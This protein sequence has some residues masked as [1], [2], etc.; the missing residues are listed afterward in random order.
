M[1]KT[2]NIRHMLRNQKHWNPF[3]DQY[4]SEKIKKDLES[5][6]AAWK[7]NDEKIP[8]PDDQSALTIVK[9][10]Q[11]FHYYFKQVYENM[12]NAIDQTK[13]HPEHV[14]K[15]LVAIG[16]SD[17]ILL[18]KHMKENIIHGSDNIR[19][20]EI[21]EFKIEA[22]NGGPLVNA[23]GA[24][25]MQVD[26]LTNLLNYLRYF[27]DTKGLHDNYVEEEIIKISSYLYTSS[28]IMFSVKD[29]YD[30]IA[31]EDGMMEE[32]HPN[33]LRLIFNDEQYPLLLKV[34]QHRIEQNVLSAILA[35]RN[36]YTENQFTIR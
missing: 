7:V 13:A 21:S 25:E 36:L 12:K 6:L 14:M 20:E 23:I 33:Q 3:S 35:G 31:W 16:N 2:Q 11:I 34:G 10:G 27:L 29:S 1:K 28:N 5:Y 17:T 30:R 26:L 8:D 24:F 18:N 9:N 19:L 4:D 32:S 15:Y 22:G